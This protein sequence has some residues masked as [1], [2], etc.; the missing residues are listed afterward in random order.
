[1]TQQINIDD[2][3]DY[4]TE[5]EAVIKHPKITGDRLVGK[6]PFHK[7]DKESFTAD[8]K[9]GMCHC[10]AGCIDGN[11]LTFLSKL[12]NTDTKDEYKNLLMKYGRYI[13]PEKKEKDYEQL[14]SF[15]LQEYA[16]S[17]KLPEEFLTGTCKAVTGKD[18]G[19]TS[20]LKLPYTLDNGKCEVFR[21]RYGNKT[22][23]W[24]KGS[25]GKLTL[26]GLWR[27]EEIRKAGKVILVEGESDTQ[28]L[29]YLSFPALGVPGASNFKER[30]IPYLE[31]LKLYIHVEPDKGGE[32]FLSKV[33]R[34]LREAGFADEVY[35]FGCS[36]FGVKDPS[37]LYLSKGAEEATKDLK[38]ALIDAVKIDLDEIADT[39]PEAIKGSPVNL[40]QPEGWIFSDKGISKISEKTALPQLICRT[41]IILTQRI[42]SLETGEEKI[43]VAFKR[44]ENWQTAIFPRSVVFTSRGITALADL[45]CTIT[46]EN[47]KMVVRFLER[48]ESENIDIIN[49]AESTSTFGWQP[50]G[51]F[52]PGHGED[53]VIDVDPSMKGWVAAYHKNGTFDEWVELMEPHRE[54]DNFR[55][56][57]A[58]S[59]TAPLLR[60][61]SQ[62]IFF[63]YNWG[64][65]KGGKTAGLKAALSAW[66]NPE[67]LMVNF[68]AT[69]VALERIAAF[70]NDLPL[71]IDERQLAGSNQESIEKIVY[72]IASGTGRTRGNKAGGL[73]AMNTW[74]TVCLATGEEPLSRSSTET[75]V[76]TRVLEIYGGPFDDEKSASEMH[77]K[78]CEHYGWAGDYF[79]ECLLRTDEKDI[80]E[81]YHKMVEEVT[82]VS[83]G[84]SGSHISGIAAVALA[85][86]MIEEWIFHNREPQRERQEE[87]ES[88][89]IHDKTWNRALLMT[90]SVMKGQ[91]DLG[92]EDDVNMNATQYVVDWILSN[93]AFFS[94][95]A[96]GT[97]YGMMSDDQNTVYIYPSLL[98]QILEKSDFSPRK[99]MKYWGQE[100][101]VKTVKENGK[102]RYSIIKKVGG[103]CS[104]MVEFHIGKYSKNIDPLVEDAHEETPEEDFRPMSESE[105]MSL[106]FD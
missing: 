4:K 64:S 1:M 42:K 37:E 3:V 79:I 75:G 105:Q 20:Y 90:Q 103:R 61:L 43:E 49:K 25:A 16:F 52:L 98:N 73:Q 87:K 39:I 100:G 56:I 71:G 54:R 84:I 38:T 74:R 35:K 93:K 77:Q 89:L 53:I 10:F 41:P 85:D 106:P 36:R 78:S 59:F 50:R 76:S 86:C 92:M 72:M 67:K 63:V 48:L 65:S 104:R 101:V 23:R 27:L 19:G 51:R 5:Y 18:R 6:C 26:Y 15:S 12:N 97:S 80:I 31:G 70:Y 7:D 95:S 82:K 94:V 66:G 55:F 32:T 34:A 22:F 28:T 21:K 62:R 46:S 8:L 57:L 13:E 24:S 45:G 58:S 2:F 81:N 9:T 11:F 69:Q 99:T 83:D 91:L 60:I 88:L 40:R 33:C 68:N 14:Q 96:I 17:K 102:T 30:M 47:A 29:W 44:D